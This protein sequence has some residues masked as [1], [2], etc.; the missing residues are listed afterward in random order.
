MRSWCLLVFIFMACG[1]PE[2]EVTA[3]IEKQTI[4]NPDITS[5]SEKIAADPKNPALYKQRA[6]LYL[7]LS[8]KEKALEDL[9]I[10]VQ[11]EPNIEGN[12]LL[13]G[14][15]YYR[16]G[17]ITKAVIV[18]EDG[19]EFHTKS[20]KI[21]LTAGRYLFYAQLYPKSLK[22]L[23]DG[24]K[25]D[26]LNGDLYFWKAM[27]HKE[28]GDTAKAISTMQTAVEQKPDF[29]EAYMQLG[30]LYKQQELAIPY[31]KNAL[32]IDSSSTEALYGIGLVQQ[33]TRKGIQAIETYKRLI[34]IDSQYEQAFYNI[35]FIYYNMDS[36]DRAYNFF[37][38]AIKVAPSYAAAYY[39]RAACAEQQGNLNQAK[40]DY[41]H[42]LNLH[43]GYEPALEGLD[44]INQ[45]I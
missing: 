21:L 23:N 9:L 27:N 39:M 1:T 2:T 19:I 8:K 6:E 29:Y 40:K 7:Q 45:S 11:L 14:D 28:Q 12:W 17:E 41:N 13:L 36:I 16:L 35:G 20:T 25:I 30:L 24:L 38:L 37:N 42:S 15:Y 31:F 26:P 43:P 5:L 44:R 33:S 4:E 3:D 22:F 18:L 10:T 32:G 34:N